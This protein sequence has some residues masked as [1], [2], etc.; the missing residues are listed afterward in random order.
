MTQ[1]Q[2]KKSIH[3]ISDII[4]NRKSKTELTGLQGSEKAY[5]ISQVH[6]KHNK[7]LFII[8]SSSKEAE[9]ITDDL[10][11]FS[12]TPCLYFPSYNSSSS[13]FIS[14]SNEIASKR[15]SILYKLTQIPLLNDSEN[16]P[17]IVLSVE[18]LL[19]KLIPKQQLCN[20]AE[21][22]IKGESTDRDKLISKRLT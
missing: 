10:N 1:N 17:I 19:Q 14:Y 21:L 7:P 2:E 11:F 13:K 15:I 16:L 8:V 12:N 5:F 20:Y 6:K 22:L 9:K 3:N 18:S 4:L